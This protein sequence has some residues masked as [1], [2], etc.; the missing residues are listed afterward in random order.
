MRDMIPHNSDFEFSPVTM[1]NDISWFANKIEQLYQLIGL[2]GQILQLDHIAMRIN[3]GKD[4]KIAERAWREWGDVISK[5]KINGRPIV[6]L[7]LKQALAIGQWQTDCVELP[8]PALGKSYPVQGWEHVE[9]VIPN[10]ACSLDE[11][12]TSIRSQF[13]RMNAD[14]DQFSKMGI[15]I[16]M[17]EPKGSGER[18]PNPTIAFK[19]QGVT[20]KLHPHSLKAVIQSEQSSL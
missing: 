14:W 11:F 8:Y 4:A 19:W 5:A 2:E 3:Q 10:E 1:F 13:P 15:T 17:S 6:V 7:E 20:I 9:F 18:L 12:V 16:K